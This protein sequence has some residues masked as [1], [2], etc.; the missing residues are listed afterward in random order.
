[1]NMYQDESQQAQKIP[2]SIESEQAVIGGLMFNE[3]KL[4]EVE[5]IITANDFFRQ[6]HKDIFSAML[7]L[8]SN[9]HPIDVI[10]LA[11]SLESSGKLESCGGLEYLSD[12]AQSVPS[13][14]NVR[15]YAKSVKD[16]STERK[17]L[18]ISSEIAQEALSARETDDKVIKAQDLVMSLE[19]SD[20]DDVAQA[21]SAIKSV[22]EEIDR[23]FN[24]E[25]GFHGLPTGIKVIDER[26]NGLRPSN[27]IIVA[28][29]PGSGKTTF[30]MTIARHTI[31][32]TK[33]PVLVFSMEMSKEEL[34]ERM[35]SDVSNIPFNFIRS[36]KLLEQHWSSLSA[37]VSRLKDSPLYIDD[38]SALT[39]N[40]MKSTA[41]KLQRKLGDLGVIVAD[42]IQLMSGGGESR[43]REI[44]KISGEL[45]AM[46][47]DL[48]VPVIALSQLN[49][50][51]EKGP[52]KRPATHHLRDSGS[53]EQDADM[54]FLLYRD[55]V[56]NENSQH[57]GIAEI[58]CGKLRN[59]ETGTDYVRS[60]LDVCRFEDMTGEVPQIQE[61]E[62]P[63]FR[64]AG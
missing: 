22:I 42:Y 10:T 3:S 53:I 8:V 46:A 7:N 17:L 52:N 25:T 30:G 2:H 50:E 27:L 9:N 12:I 41:R 56:Y 62:P 49:R 23:R 38:R 36:G 4:P 45:K 11:G 59:G 55:E 58:I 35:T 20:G 40:Q 29:R 19:A 21:N 43:E 16:R 39:V 63:K 37:G 14:A 48:G 26:T 32:E 57:K 18:T 5:E 31:L 51:C 54:I 15:S 28:G 1:M 44:S 24:S 60:R 34:M 64:R 13:A 33:R 61:I 6:A 47:K